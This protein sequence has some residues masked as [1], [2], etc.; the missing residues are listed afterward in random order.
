MIFWNFGR[1]F[2]F[3]ENC[4]KLFLDFLPEIW[5]RKFAVIFAE[6]LGGRV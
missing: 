5:A 1:G 3:A 4:G 6:N 2:Y